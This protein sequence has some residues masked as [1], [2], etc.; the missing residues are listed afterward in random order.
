M[1]S[2]AEKIKILIL[3][4]GS[5]GKTALAVIIILLRIHLITKPIRF[6]TIAKH[7]NN[8]EKCCIYFI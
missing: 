8:F 6:T 2:A 5:V 7:T 4:T 3:G 1:E